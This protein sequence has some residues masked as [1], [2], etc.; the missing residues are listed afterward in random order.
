ML[1]E[2]DSG[3]LA[4]QLSHDAY[5]LQDVNMQHAIQNVEYVIAALLQPKV[6]KDGD[7]W[8][9]LY[10]DNIQDGVCGFGETP[11]KAILDFNRAWNQG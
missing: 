2:T 4:S 1:N 7:R 9:V 6:Y 11:Y 3:T 10:G 8:C 5:L